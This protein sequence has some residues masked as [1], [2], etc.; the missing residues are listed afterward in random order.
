M[1]Y[2]IMRSLYNTESRNQEQRPGVIPNPMTTNRNSNTQSHARRVV[3]DRSNTLDLKTLKE[4]DA[5]EVVHKLNEGMAQLKLHL[6]SEEEPHDCD[7]FIFDLTCTLAIACRAPHGEN[8][9]KIL[10]AL[11]G[12]V[13]LRSKIPRLLDRAQ[14]SM[15][16]ND[17]ESRRM[18][19][20]SLIIVFTKYLTHL[21]SSYVDLPYVQLKLALD[22]SNID[23]K[24]E[25]QK[26]LDDV[27]QARDDIIK[28]ERQKHGK[29]YTNRAGEKPPND[30]RDIPICPTNKEITT[31]ERPFLRQ[32][33]T[34]G[35]YDNAEH[36]LDVQFR[37]LREDFLE[38]LREGIQEIVR[39]LPRQQRKQSM[40]KY[41]NVRIL[42]KDFTWS[43]IIHQVQIDV[44]G[45]NTTR[46]PRS[47]RL[48]FGSFLC[49]SKDNFRTMLFATVSKREPE[50]LKQGRI[51]IRF[52]EDQD[53]LGIESRNCVYQMV[54]SPAY[55]EAYRYVLKGLKELDE[56]TLPFKKYLVEC[57]EQ[58]DPPEY[59]RHNDTEREPVCY[60]LS[61]AL[62]IPD[63]TNATAVPVLHREAWS[64]VETLHLNSSQLEA[65]RTAITTEFSVIQGPPGTGKT[66]VGA[67]IVRCLL[68][69]RTAWDPQRNSPMLMVCYTNHALDQ[70]LEKVLEFIPKEGIIRVGGRCK[71]Q[72]LETCNLK[73]FTY[74]Y[75]LYQ[76]RHRV[77]EKMTNNDK[78]RKNLERHLAKADKQLLEFNDLEQLMHLKHAD[79]LCSAIFPFNVAYE[80]RTPINTFKLWFCNNELLNSCNQRTETKTENQPERQ[81]NETIFGKIGA[82]EDDRLFK[83]AGM[84]KA[85]QFSDETNNNKPPTCEIGGASMAKNSLCFS[86][87]IIEVHA[88]EVMTKTH[89]N[90]NKTSSGQQTTMEHC[91]NSNLPRRSSD[92]QSKILK[93]QLLS[94]ASNTNDEE[95]INLDF[96]NSEMSRL[97]KEGDN[98]GQ[99]R[100]PETEKEYTN[101]GVHGVIAVEMEADL[102]QNQR[103]LHGDED[104][105]KPI[106]EQTNT[107]EQGAENEK[108]DDDGYT[109]VSHRKGGKGKGR[110]WLDTEVRNS[111][112]KRSPHYPLFN[113]NRN[114]TAKT[115][116]PGRS[117]NKKS[118]DFITGDINSVRQELEK[119]TMMS[120][121]EA[122]GVDN[123]WIL[124]RTDRFRLYLLWV[125][126][127][128][129][130]YRLQI[131]R[132]EQQYDQLCEDL[133]AV[134]FQEEEQVIRRATVV[135]MTTS[136]AAR[137]HSML[138]RVA[139]KI[140]VIEEAAEVMEAHIITSLSKDTKHT[141]L[142]GDHKQLRPK[143]TVYELAQKY[144]LEISLFERMVMNSMDCKR[145]STQHRMR[146]EIAALTKGIYDHDII[147]HESVCH[148]QDISGV[149]HNVFFIDHCQPEGKVDN[150][151]SFCNPHEAT[152]LVALCNY[153]LLQGYDRGKITILT[154]Y[155]GQLL[156]LQEQMPRETFEGVKVCAVD[157]FQGEENDIILLSLVRS[158]SEGRIGFL[159]ES[160][161]ICVALSRARKGF[162]CIGNFS[163]LK[164]QSKVWKE[165]CDDLKAKDAIADSLKLVCKTHNNV[166]S[167]RE[168]SEFNPLGG[169]NMLCGVRL[170]CGHACEK[171]CHTSNHLKDEC[172]KMCLNRCPNEHQCLCR[173]HYPHK[174][175][176]CRYKMSKTVLKCGHEQQIPCSVDPKNF[177][178]RMK[179]E[180][181]LPCEHNCR[182][183]CGQECTLQCKVNYM[184]SLPCGHKKTLPCYKNPKV[185]NQCNKNCTKLLECGHPCSKTCREECQCNTMIDIQ[186]PCQHTKRALCREKDSPMQCSE[187]C[188]KKL[189][190]GHECPGICYEDC[191]MNRCKIDVIKVL[192][193]GHQQSV[194]CYQNPQT[195]FCYAPC[196]R[197]L[198]CGHKCSSV[199]GRSCHEVECEEMC[200]SKCERGHSCTR[201][202]HFGSSCDDCLVEVNMKIPECGHS[203]KAP[204]FVDPAALKCNQPCEKLRVCGH[205]CKE[206][207]SK[208][209]E[210]RSCKELVTRT[211]LCNHMVSLACHRNPTKFICKKEVEVHLPC[212]H[213]ATLECH[214]TKAGLGS[215]LCKTKV[216]KEL[217]CKHK[218]TLPCFKNPGECICRRKVDVQ[219][220]CGH[221]KILHCPTV[222]A[223]LTDVVC[224]VKLPRTLPCNHKAI[225]P[226]Y[227]KL[228]EHCCK[229]KVEIKLSCGHAKLTTCFSMP[230]EVQADVCD[231]KVTRKLPCG[232]KKEMHCSD[233]PGKICCD[234]PCERFLVCGHPC[235]KKCGD[236]CADF[237][238]AVVLKKNLNC[239][240]HEISCLCSKDVSQLI[241]TNQCKQNLTCGH[242]CPGKCSDDC[243][244]FKCQ[245]MVVKNL[246]CAGN[247]SLKM[248][249]SCDPNSVTCQERCSKNL[250]CGHPCPGMC[251]EL[252]ERIKCRQRV[253][254]QYPCGHKDQLPCFRSKNAT[255]GAPC[256]RRERCKHAC[257]GVCGKP[258]SDY[259]CDVVVDRSLSCG[260]KVKMPCSRSVED[261]QCSAPC[262]TKLSCS[263]QCSGTCNDCQQRGEHEI[264]LHPCSR[265]LICLHR[266]KA[267]CSEPCPPCDR[268]CN[269]RCPHTKC[270]NRCSEPCEPCKQ[271]CTW[272]CPHYQCNNLCGEECDRPRCDAPCPKKLA[273]RHP[274]IGLCG[275]NCP[276]ICAVCDAKRLSSMLDK[277]R[278]DANEVARYLQLDCGHILPVEEM[279]AW[280]IRERGN[281]VQVIQCPR[282]SMAISFSFR[283]G[284][285]IKRRL[286]SYESVKK[287]INDFAND[288]SHFA[289]GLSPTDRNYLRCEMQT[290]KFPRDVLDAFQ[291]RLMVQRFPSTVRPP[292]VLLDRI[293]VR[294]I[295]LIFTMKN[296]LFI[297]HQAK[298]VQ[299]RLQVCSKHQPEINQQSTTINQVLENILEYL[300]EPMDL[301]NLD[302][303]YLHVRT[304]S[305]FVSIFEVRHEAI[306]QHRSLSNS[307][308]TRLE[309]ARSRLNL[310]LQGNNDAL[311]MDWLKRI[312]DLLR[313]EVGLAS[314]PPVEPKAFESFPGFSRGVWKLC[315]HREVYFT[316]SIVRDGEDVTVVIKSCRRCV[317]KGESD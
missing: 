37:L 225:L 316:R 177:S 68:E 282:C 96:T 250:D 234:A 51:D 280:M 138:Q 95:G 308:E 257:Q 188:T 189:N 54:E 31:R 182:N 71:S 153:L 165:V 93:N 15:T 26:A 178:C 299:N 128:R 131:R 293:K 118:K 12:S 284:S 236:D 270:T 166:T 20:D 283:Y 39:D 306:K 52:I 258:C 109:L 275:E 59:L 196:P 168:A 312:V 237:K 288:A 121:H 267:T 273:C 317:D 157:N 14:V 218:I 262:K 64:S 215:A 145:L 315:E 58:V 199:C 245:K 176:R 92:K 110:P 160:N 33:I 204:C 24:D 70:F 124:S 210:A 278:G 304:F 113:E 174:C 300:K 130:H 38:P 220:A 171:K 4:K 29:R 43:G 57:R 13:F 195:A 150:L 164:S 173:C 149:C 216:E 193:C 214:V 246:N 46:W 154:M 40:R 175:P 28:G 125:E 85:P 25:L 30:F 86:D 148:F 285:I 78:D 126:S 91:Q 41:P 192:P 244:Q 290:M 61:K 45:V 309:M 207:C 261:M 107:V 72:S 209:C 186:L 170:P 291:R 313:K 9:N 32:N 274:C 203:T 82:R 184:K 230:D 123:I 1:I 266:C 255:C 48:I 163:L 229:E 161:R 19:I 42:S 100:P 8:I 75:K 305:V 180:K 16:L 179:C 139:P 243:S 294:N 106:S 260:H 55:F 56:A 76:E 69:N 105:M 80:C 83:E 239:G 231:T 302:E 84:S 112:E 286:K 10:A 62:D 242:K 146:P 281:D 219:L 111:Y 232:H 289:E 187:K 136:G 311:P 202:C 103:W 23:R 66:Y 5:T 198:N 238:C 190:C 122:I 269:G 167:V 197:K 224:R 292:K 142:I 94:D 211:L 205:P 265:L 301:K 181:M 36:Y 227:M 200:Q 65:L 248:P 201:R 18:F 137:Y 90:L 240:H 271:P 60:D 259:P 310:F 226:C 159:A 74:R 50:E 116:T 27:K 247:H 34:K 253:E 99:I 221:K 89:V 144:N 222:T 88:S 11:K 264:C 98:I 212:G 191:T 44:T 17:Q 97:T 185:Y 251:S 233:K 241:C 135:G 49:L 35:R 152:F 279:D 81:P 47:K 287:E 63:A 297:M 272:S 22:Q 120:T 162:Y 314:L 102:I 155:T 77:H 183:E 129:E 151:Q 256:R 115:N 276:T 53:V 7:E 133:E 307:G 134:R 127:Y 296:H 252:C 101:N 213:R 140:V 254:K 119:E 147:D 298:K 114:K 172:F 132:G 2:V 141:I 228:E 108:D 206:L 249:C 3:P 21:P 117:K 223:G 268:K 263:H 303:V 143:A 67:K 217:S 169:C 87:P 208:N 158:N 277:G 79:Q 6:R 73:N 295:P 104:R 156:V 194:P 235:P